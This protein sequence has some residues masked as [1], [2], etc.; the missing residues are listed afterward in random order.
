MRYVKEME[1]LGQNDVRTDKYR[2]CEGMVY[3]RKREEVE[4]EKAIK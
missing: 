1:S 2:Y 4:S 3:S